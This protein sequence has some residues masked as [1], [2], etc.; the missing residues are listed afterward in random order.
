MKGVG[1]FVKLGCL[2]YLALLGCGGTQFKDR[3]VSKSDTRYR[4]G[5]LT[6]S[7]KRI[8]VEQN[9]VAWLH[10]SEGT[11]IQVNSRCE[12]SLDLPLMTLTNHLLIGFTDREFIEQKSVQLDG[13]EALRSHIRAKL[14]GVPRELVI[15]V[16]KKNN[17]VYDF[18]YVATP[19][20]TFNQFL[21]DFER[22][23]VGF[24]TLN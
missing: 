10:Q 17:C 3:E 18:A 20:A 14:D 8:E 24:H 23:V 12:R 7:W 15:Y 9:D 4:V 22:F 13:R 2:A 19:G 16:L 1:G 11:L 6:P 21:A 5:P